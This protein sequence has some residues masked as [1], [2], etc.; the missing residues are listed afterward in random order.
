MY[1][2]SFTELPTD[3]RQIGPAIIES[4]TRLIRTLAENPLEMAEQV[5]FH[6]STILRVDDAVNIMLAIIYKKI[7]YAT[8]YGGVRKPKPSRK[9][10]C[11]NELMRFIVTV[12]ASV[13]IVY[14]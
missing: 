9:N 3:P 6:H 11:M 7:C 5:C 1:I 14:C 8:L 2:T 10:K 4:H 13:V 12:G